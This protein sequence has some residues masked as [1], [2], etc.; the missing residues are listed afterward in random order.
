MSASEWLVSS[1]LLAVDGA[2]TCQA[3]YQ[4]VNVGV[5]VLDSLSV[6]LCPSQSALV[7]H[8]TVS[9]Q[10]LSETAYFRQGEYGLDPESISGYGLRIRITSKI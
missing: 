7:L 1:Y 9:K 5:P 10:G 4:R 2:R 6:T 3:C 8:E